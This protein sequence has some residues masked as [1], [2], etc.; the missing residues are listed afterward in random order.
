MT[1]VHARVTDERASCVVEHEV[2]YSKA[3]A[4]PDALEAVPLP[5]QKLLQRTMRKAAPMPCEDPFC[6]AGAIETR[7]RAAAVDVGG[8]YLGTGALSEMDSLL[9]TVGRGVRGSRAWLRAPLMRL[10]LRMRPLLRA[11]AGYPLE[12]QGCS[13]LPPCLWELGSRAVASAPESSSATAPCRAKRPLPGRDLEA[14]PLPVGNWQSS[15][16]HG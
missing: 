12:E 8:A 14:K 11:A 2:A 1:D 15:S 13:F 16:A 10:K 4:L 6:E 5:E 9:V 3:R 7:G